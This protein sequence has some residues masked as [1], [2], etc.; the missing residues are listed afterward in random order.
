MIDTE[1]IIQ[2]LDLFI[3]KFGGIYGDYYVGITDNPVGRFNYDHNIGLANPY[4]F[5]EIDKTEAARLI[6]R[7]FIDLG[8]DGGGDGPDE[9]SVYV[10]KKGPRTKP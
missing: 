2:E 3:L 4:I 6:E 10:Y 8:C 1:S 9:G 7:Y 5:K